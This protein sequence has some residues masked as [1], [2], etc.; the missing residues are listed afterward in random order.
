LLKYKLLILLFGY[1]LFTS[2]TCEKPFDIDT[3]ETAKLALNSIFTPGKPMTVSLSASRPIISA[4][5]RALSGETVEVTTPS[6]EIISLQLKTDDMLNKWFVD[7]TFFPEV[8]VNYVINASANAV[9]PIISNNIIPESVG[10]LNPSF[11][12][13]L[14]ET[15]QF[16]LGQKDIYINVEFQ[17]EDI[18]GDQFYH[19]YAYRQRIL[20][21]DST[22][23]PEYTFLNSFLI[24]DLIN[25]DNSTGLG[26]T[27]L[28]YTDNS[29]LFKDDESVASNIVSFDIGFTFPHT[30]EAIRNFRFELRTVSEEYYKFHI[31]K[32]KQELVQNDEFAEP[33]ISFSNIEGGLGLFGGYNSVQIDTIRLQ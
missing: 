28:V 5:A 33:I 31:A 18:P 6:G 13:I 29:L 23:V 32:R 8:G 27:G 7:S 12:S 20:W 15:S 10:I 9:E 30:K 16:K 14:V 24:N 17:L 21:A 25:L 1:F 22:G 11:D 2:S 3:S 4:D 19:F 26:S